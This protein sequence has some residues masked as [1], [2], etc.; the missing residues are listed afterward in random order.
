MSSPELRLIYGEDSPMNRFKSFVISHSIELEHPSVEKRLGA[1]SLADEA[2]L[3]PIDE[4]E[5]KVINEDGADIYYI[6]LNKS[7]DPE[8]PTVYEVWYDDDPDEAQF[9]DISGNLI[10]DT[11]AS[12]L[13]TKLTEAQEAGRLFKM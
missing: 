1:Y 8:D 10:S 11:E 9:Y 4:I 6:K 7:T 5:F 3:I 2:Q 13:L 12:Q